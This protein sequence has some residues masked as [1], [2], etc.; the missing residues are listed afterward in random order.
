MRH[1]SF[2]WCVRVTEFLLE[3]LVLY[4]KLFIH[5]LLGRSRVQWPPEGLP[6]TMLYS[7]W[8]I[9]CLITGYP[10]AFSPPGIC[11]HSSF[12]LECPDLHLCWSRSNSHFRVQLKTLLNKVLPS[13]VVN[14]FASI[15]EVTLCNPLS[16]L[17]LLP[18]TSV[19]NLLVLSIFFSS[20]NHEILLT[21]RNEH[22]LT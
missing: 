10:W 2:S 9:Q 22:N 17:P 1:F 12:C 21:E 18:Y 14:F 6:I 13:S 19:S 4:V 8:L 16:L 15:F 7:H 20:F 5:C 11:A 3:G